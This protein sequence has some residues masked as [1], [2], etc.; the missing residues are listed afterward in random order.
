MYILT[1]RSDWTISETSKSI[2]EIKVS[3]ILKFL[4][5]FSVSSKL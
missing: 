4:S 3:E 5:E 1:V 2:V